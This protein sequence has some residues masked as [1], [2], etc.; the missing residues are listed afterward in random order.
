MIAGVTSPPWPFSYAAVSVDCFFVVSGYLISSSFDRDPN[1]MRFYIRRIFRIYPLYVVVVAAQAAILLVL[2]PPGTSV[3]GVMVLRYIIANATFANFLQPD[4]GNDVLSSL[5]VGTLNPSMWT[6]KIELGFYL[7]MPFIWMATRRLG[8]SLLV[9]LFVG[10]A[11]YQ[12]TLKHAGYFELARQLPGQLQFFVLGIGIYRLRGRPALSPPAACAVTLVVGCAI[13]AMHHTTL[14]V[15]YPLM[16]AALVALVALKTPALSV[17]T[18]M[19]YGVYLFHGPIIQLSLLLG[20]DRRDWIGLV[21]TIA[22]VFALAWIAER[23]IES[24]G[25]DLGRSL[26]RHASQRTPSTSAS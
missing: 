10:S 9:M 5:P 7:I 11:A 25:I 12:L 19:S 13:T 16:I 17:E 22:V 3:A 21:L 6:L 1:L 8:W 14:P 23:I 18:D 4:L 2:T 20:I 24:P 15:I 26:I